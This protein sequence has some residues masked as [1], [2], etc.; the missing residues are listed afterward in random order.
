MI[1]VAKEL[2]GGR[3]HYGDVYM[4]VCSLLLQKPSQ[5]VRI[6]LFLVESCKFEDSLPPGGQQNCDIGLGGFSSK[7][8]DRSSCDQN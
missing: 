6:S 7:V 8:D 4:L 3:C 2:N 1:L 5:G